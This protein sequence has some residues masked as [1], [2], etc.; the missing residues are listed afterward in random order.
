MLNNKNCEASETHMDKYQVFVDDNFHIGDEKE[1][2]KIGEYDTREEAVS[3][4]KEIVERYF[5]KIKKGQHSYI[6]LWEGYMVF[7]ED[8]FIF[9]DDPG[10]Q[11]SA[12]DYAKERCHEFAK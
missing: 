9:N 1:R 5:Q 3:K 8:P 11:F 10:C 12:W 6:E 4:C 7:G 2:Y